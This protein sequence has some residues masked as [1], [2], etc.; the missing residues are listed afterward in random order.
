VPCDLSGTWH[1]SPL[2]L[3]LIH[4]SFVIVTPISTITSSIYSTDT[5][6]IFYFKSNYYYYLID[7][8]FGTYYPSPFFSFIVH[9][10][11]LRSP[12]SLPQFTQMV[13]NMASM[14]VERKSLEYYCIDN[15]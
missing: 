2:P 10:W 13:R 3:L 9:S 7:K 11:L 12:Q 6:F 15:S 1:L 4:G 14:K 5:V 8:E